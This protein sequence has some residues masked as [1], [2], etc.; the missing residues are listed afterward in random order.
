MNR[1]QPHHLLAVVLISLVFYGCASDPQAPPR[2]TTTP[3]FTLLRQHPGALIAA[4]LVGAPYR[5]GGSTPRG[6]DCSGLVYFSFRQA[7]IRI[8][9]ST[10]SQ[11][12]HAFR[13]PLDQL[14]P[15]DLVFFKLNRRKVSHVGIY[16]GNDLFIHAPSN[17]K[18]V[19]L[20]SMNDPFWHNRYVAAGRYF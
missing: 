15:G 16:A 18:Q 8:P 11:Y 9:R 17:E 3:D 14:Q 20:T 19:S 13:V 2:T 4:N 10:L 12:R 7:G 6:F 5:Y 1:P